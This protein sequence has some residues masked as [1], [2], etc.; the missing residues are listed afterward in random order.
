MKLTIAGIREVDFI[1]KKDGE[2]ITGFMYI[3]YPEKGSP[4]EFF[5]KEDDLEITETASYLP[6]SFQEVPIEQRLDF[7]SGKVKFKRRYEK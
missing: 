2:Q 1:S 5:S 3:A 7:A 6:D 4:F